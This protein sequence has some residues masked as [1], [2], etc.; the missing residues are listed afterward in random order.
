MSPAGPSVLLLRRAN[1][2][3]SAEWALPGG[4][5]HIDEDAD[6]EAAARRVLKEKTG[7]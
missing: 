3:L 5:I 4:W 7:V 2:S 6:L 1:A